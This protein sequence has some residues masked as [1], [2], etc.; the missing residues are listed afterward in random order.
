MREITTAP[1][2]SDRG[3]GHGYIEGAEGRTL[4]EVLNFIRKNTNSWGVITILNRNN[5]VLR[6]FDYN[7]FN[8]NNLFYH[9]DVR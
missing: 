5:Y 4:E 8:S 2:L 7:T 3:D 1:Q 6:K 9:K